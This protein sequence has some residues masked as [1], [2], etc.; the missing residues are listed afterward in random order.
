MKKEKLIKEFFNR[1]SEV[2]EEQFEKGELCKCGKRLPCRSK[3]L[4]LNAYANIIFRDILEVVLT[5][6]KEEDR[7]W[8]C[9]PCN[10]NKDN[11]NIEDFKKGDIF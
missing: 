4:V 1:L 2:L 6:K 8:A 9:R 5:D 3:A 7:V 11:L 10:T